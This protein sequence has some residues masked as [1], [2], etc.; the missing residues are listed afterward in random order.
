MST[1]F[2]SISGWQESWPINHSSFTNPGCNLSLGILSPKKLK[3]NNS[4]FPL[5]HFWPLRSTEVKDLNTHSSPSPYRLTS[6]L[7]QRNSDKNAACFKK[8]WTLHA[9]VRENCTIL[10][11]KCFLVCKVFEKFA[12]FRERFFCTRSALR[13]C[14]CWHRKLFRNLV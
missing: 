5:L 6:L 12:S 14:C 7:A 11:R 1:T 10:S 13:L 4:S 8:S 3:S 9:A 2:S